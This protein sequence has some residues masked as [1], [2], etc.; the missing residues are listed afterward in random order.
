[1]G[2]A[3][4]IFY[5]QCDDRISSVC[6]DSSYSD[7]IALAKELCIKHISL[8]DF[9]IETCLYIVKNTILSKNNL[10][11]YRLRPIDYAANI[12]CP[13]FFVHALN[14]ELVNVEHSL[15]LFH[16]YGGK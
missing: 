13:G 12:K 3:T 16:K 15:I 11:I 1:M 7:F 5:A 10:D 8:P 4:A 9:L 14:D 2:A 6:Y